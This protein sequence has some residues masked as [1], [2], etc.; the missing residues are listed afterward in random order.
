LI[1][2]L[3]VRLLLRASVPEQSNNQ[4]L[5]HQPAAQSSESTSE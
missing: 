1:E 4:T 2:C 5:E 3:N